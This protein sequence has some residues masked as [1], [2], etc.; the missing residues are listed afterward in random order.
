MPVETGR[1]IPSTAQAADK[2][3]KMRTI[4]EW[5]RFRIAYRLDRHPLF[6][7]YDLATWALGMT[8]FSEIDRA[9]RCTH[10]PYFNETCGGCYCGKHSV[11]SASLE[12]LPAPLRTLAPQIDAAIQELE[13]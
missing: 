4:F 6:C 8:P 9:G 2:G 1:A 13:S 5:L 11:Y 3:D 7:W 10:P 12:T